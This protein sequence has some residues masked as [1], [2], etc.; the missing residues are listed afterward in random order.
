MDATTRSRFPRPRNHETPRAALIVAALC[1][2]IVA[3]LSFAAGYNLAQSTPTLCDSGAWTDITR[4]GEYPV[5]SQTCR[6]G[7]TVVELD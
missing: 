5:W 3:G 1:A 7:R 2:T 4:P 6:D